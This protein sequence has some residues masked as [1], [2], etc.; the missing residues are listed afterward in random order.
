MLD[1]PPHTGYG[2]VWNSALPRLASIVDL[3]VEDERPDVW[4]FDGHGGDP[5]VCGPVVICLAEVNWG[6]T[7][8]DREH[9]PDFVRWIAPATEAAARRA[10][11]R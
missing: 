4:L 9:D 2:R 8:F 3:V 11:G 5:G 10:C 6:K 1:L 7:G